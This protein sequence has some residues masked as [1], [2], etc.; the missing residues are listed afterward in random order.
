MGSARWLT[1]LAGAV[2]ASCLPGVARA[3]DAAPPDAPAPSVLPSDLEAEPY[4]GRVIG[5]VLFEGL[6]RVPERFARNQT[7]SAEG[8]PLEWRIIRDDLRRLERLGE[9]QRVEADVVVR[10]D[11]TVA[12]VYR[13]EEAPII[14]D[15]VVVGNRQVPDQDIAREINQRVSLIPGVP[16][17][18]Y[19]IGQAQ[20]AI[21]ELYRSKGFYQV[22]VT[23]DRGELE[24]NGIVIFRVREGERTQVTGV[25]FQGNDSVPAKQIRPEIQTKERF[26]LFNSPLDNDTLDADVAAIVELFRNRGFLDV[27]VSRQITLSPNAREAIVTFVIEQ[28]P[29]YLLRHVIVETM[30]G[31]AWDDMAQVVSAGQIR[32]WMPLK[33]G[34]VYEANVAEASVRA[35]VDAYNKMGYVDAGA[36]RQDLRAIDE[37]RVDLRIRISEGERF[38][39]GLVTIQGNDLTQSKVIRRRTDLRPGQVLDGTA[40]VR[41]ERDLSQSGL[42]EVNPAFGDPPKVTIQPED[43]ANPGYRDVLVEVAETNTGSLSFGAAVSSDAGVVGTIRLTQRNFDIADVPDSWD[44]L[45]TGK[46]F[47]GAGQTFN[48]TL[49]PGNEVS[50]Y[51]LT[52]AEPALFESP[53]GLSVSGFFRDRVFSDYD[54]N[55]WGFNTR[56]ARR[57]GTRWTGGFSFRLE[58]V[59]LDDIDERAPVDVFAVEDQNYID[60]FGFDLQRTTV[61]NRF[62]PTKGTRTEFVVLRYGLITGDFEFWR[63]NIEHQVFLTIDEDDFGRETVLALK[64]ASGWIPEGPD[65]APVYERIYLGGRNFRG[66]DFRGIGPVGVRNDTGEKG[67]DHVGGTFSFFL[68]AEVEKPLWQDVFAV[69]GFVDSGTL[70]DAVSL[71]DYR[72][73]IGAGIRLYLPQFG[74]APLAFDFA[75]PLIK[76]D[77]DDEQYFS[78]SI[79]LPF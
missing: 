62:R 52:I 56:L 57:F 6:E 79:D 17:D 10:P 24:E 23:P 60:S 25:R 27:R 66:F 54:E 49:A 58:S 55:R 32:A 46:A 67:D 61:D 21:E 41:T 37:P 34:D 76:E 4:E 78:F 40:V 3:Q 7:R 33:P 18:E 11:G 47:R 39:T 63:L 8:R 19:R 69:V 50:T 53:Y 64:A 36:R 14:Q 16:I 15:I 75:Y 65:D 74:Q 30:R 73:S 72:V 12:V 38:K 42:F 45:F 20:R 26:L 9:F 5:A 31:E 59:E 35:V 70:N 13:V 28:G 2:I 1:V 71:S 51:A 48:L 22:E 29:Q 68:G 77:T 43:P 44:E